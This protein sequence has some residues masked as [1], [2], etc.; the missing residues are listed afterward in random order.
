MWLAEGRRVVYSG[1]G[2]WSNDLVVANRDGSDAHAIRS[3]RA[4][5]YRLAVSPDGRW[6][7]YVSEV[8]VRLRRVR[9]AARRHRPPPADVFA[10]PRGGP[11]AVEP[12]RQASRLQSLDHTNGSEGLITTIGRDGSDLTH[13]TE[14]AVN[15]D[16][17]WAPFLVAR[18]GRIAFMGESWLG[19]SAVH[20]V[21]VMDADGSDRACLTGWDEYTWLWAWLA[22]P[23]D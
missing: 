20:A 19:D 9:D 15:F 3:D 2:K 6:I 8:R 17:A 21:Y 22:P 18:R 23:V 7:A 4:N 12:R 1:P 11:P 10:G 5:D 16:R 13:L 14:D